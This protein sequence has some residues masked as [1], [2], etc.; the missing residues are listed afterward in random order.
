MSRA[1][2]SRRTIASLWLVS[3]KIVG[4]WESVCSGSFGLPNN[5]AH[6]PSFRYCSLFT[7]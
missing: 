1:F 7:L 3:H 6:P 4:W 2:T 5:I